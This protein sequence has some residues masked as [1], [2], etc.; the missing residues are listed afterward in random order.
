M[1]HAEENE[2][3]TLYLNA[4]DSVATIICLEEMGHP[5][6]TTSLKIMPVNLIVLSIEPRKKIYQK[7][8]I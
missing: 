1:G 7:L 4:T 2:V 6:A 8:Y 3:E 5:Q